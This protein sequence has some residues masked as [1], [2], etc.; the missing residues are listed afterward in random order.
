MRSGLD[1]LTASVLISDRAFSTRGARLLI[2]DDNPE[3]RQTIREIL[4]TLQYEIE[5]AEGGPEALVLLRRRRFDAVLTD[6]MMPT[7]SGF[8]LLAAIKQSEPLLPVIVVTGFPSINTAIEA[9]RQGAADFLTKPFEITLIDH[10]VKKV[11][12]ERALVI[13]NQQLQAELNQKAVIEALN[14][15]LREKVDELTK[16]YAISEIMSATQSNDSLL[17][18]IVRVA[19]E[20]TD[21]ARASIM[22]VDHA[23]GE[24]VLRAAIGLP[25]EAMTG[26]RRRIG[27]G[28]AGQVALTGRPCRAGQI[29][30]SGPAAAGATAHSYKYASF[31][32]IP[33][34]VGEE[35]FAVLNLTEKH[36]GADFTRKDEELVD[37]LTR[38]AAMKLENN[39]LYEG[40]YANLLDTLRALV[41]TIEA[42]DPYTRQHSQRVTEYALTLGKL[43]GLGHEDLE[44]FGFAGI[45]HKPGR[46][47]DQEFDLIKRHPGIGESIVMPLGL[48]ELE[49]SIIR[50]HHERIDGRG[51]PDGL[52]GDQIPMPVRIV[53]VSDSFDAITSDRP[54][55]KAKTWTEALDELYRNAGTQ[56]DA[57]VVRTLDQALSQGLIVPP[58]SPPLEAE[59]P[60]AV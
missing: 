31:L 30:P 58:A 35:V 24:L 32:S 16:L 47:T 14:R 19:A 57:D 4:E 33:L 7:M 46:L 38:K 28:V 43:M 39:A 36:N 13:K 52:R 40:I 1:K 55:R 26:V 2:V 10:V 59:L 3:S 20:I 18:D 25:K 21:C 29:L 9:M 60:I 45:L 8:E 27:E 23:R 5:E 49:R 11:L 51:Y 42:R 54:Y 37:N 44:T 50:H 34:F 17:N 15:Q 12:R 53:S 22:L 41:T 56:F 6:L 48:I